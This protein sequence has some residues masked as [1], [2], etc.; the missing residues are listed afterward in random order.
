MTWGVGDNQAD[1]IIGKKFA[2]GN[3]SWIAYF[4]SSAFS[5]VYCKQTDITFV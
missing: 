2:D 1:T 5:F 3:V 4:L